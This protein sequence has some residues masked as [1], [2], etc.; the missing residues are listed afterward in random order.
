MTEDAWFFVFMFSSFLLGAFVDAIWNKVCGV[1]QKFKVCVDNS[2]AIRGFDQAI[3]IA[4]RYE[5]ML[6]TIN[7]KSMMCRRNIELIRPPKEGW[8]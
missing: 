5:E 7:V 6:D 1:K 4:K 8:H 2:E 3:Q